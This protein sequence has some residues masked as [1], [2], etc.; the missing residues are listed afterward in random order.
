MTKKGDD[1]RQKNPKYISTRFVHNETEYGGSNGGNDVDQTACP[2]GFSLVKIV[3]AHKE[4][5]KK[6][7]YY[8]C[9]ADFEFV[10]I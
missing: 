5:S 10:F 1:Y 7:K 9:F 2:V 8:Y 6:T 4:N 3:L